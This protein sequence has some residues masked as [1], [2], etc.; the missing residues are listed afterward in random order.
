MGERRADTLGGRGVGKVRPY[1]SLHAL[2]LPSNTPPA[3]TAREFARVAQD[4]AEWGRELGFQ[5][6]GIT[7]TELG[8]AEE[9]LQRWLAAGR[10]GNMAYMARHGTARS[11]PAELVPG[12]L[13]VISARMNYW[14]GG[15]DAQAALADP[16]RAYVARYA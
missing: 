3:A 16:S 15:A 4:I 13:R 10:H 5:E 11:R 14:P 12:T 6:I 9:H 2:S 7:D 8:E 1:V